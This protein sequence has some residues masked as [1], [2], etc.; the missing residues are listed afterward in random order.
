MLEF[1]TSKTG[2]FA[3]I[4]AIVGLAASLWKFYKDLAE[5]REKRGKKQAEKA[6]AALGL[7]IA[8]QQLSDLSLSSNSYDLRFVV[9]NRGTSKLIMRALR[10]CVESREECQQTRDSYTMAPLQVHKHQVRLVA[11]EDVYDIRKRNFSPGNEPLA[12][13]PGEAHAFVV[14]LVSEETMLYAFHV[15]AE[16]YGAADPDKSDVVRAD[17]LRAAFPKRVS[18]GPYMGQPHYYSG[19]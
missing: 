2:I 18:A 15:E 1:L 16:W 19:R 10:L 17:S 9:T 7:A 12:F 14:K 6:R 4:V 5:E 11:G 13:D 8:D 3:A